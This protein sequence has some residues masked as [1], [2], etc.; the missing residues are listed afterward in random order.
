[1]IDNRKKKKKSQTTLAVIMD[2]LFAKNL[3]RNQMGIDW[4]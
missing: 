1:M 2:F 3:L 4:G